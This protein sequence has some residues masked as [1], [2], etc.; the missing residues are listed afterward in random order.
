MNDEKNI[1]K[2]FLSYKR[3]LISKFGNKAL[4]DDEI[5]SIGSQLFGPKWQGVHS[6]DRMK[7][8]P[9]FQIINTGG[10]NSPGRHWV[11]IFISP[12]TIYIYDS[13]GRDTDSILKSIRAKSKKKKLKIVESDRDAEQRG[14]SEI[15]GILSISWLCVVK[16]RGIRMALLI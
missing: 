6:H 12:S 2:E 15:C 7:F 8:K 5:N 13:F 10:E 11:G 3:K 14:Y 4:Y 16:N 1:H 9:G